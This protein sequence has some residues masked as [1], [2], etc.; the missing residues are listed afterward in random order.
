MLILVIASDID[1]I[2]N[3]SIIENWYEKY[4]SLLNKYIKISFPYE[5]LKIEH[6]VLKEEKV[7]HHEKN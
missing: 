3:V 4:Q 7:N 6:G 1:F 5:S 2:D